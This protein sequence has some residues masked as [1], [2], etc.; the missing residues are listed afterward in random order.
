MLLIS[1]WTESRLSH[2]ENK[3]GD[4]R[5]LCSDNSLRDRLANRI[6]R[7]LLFALQ[8]EGTFRKAEP[9]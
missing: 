7:C 3:Q 8:E 1:S 4:I 5:I 6:Y 9:P 2:A